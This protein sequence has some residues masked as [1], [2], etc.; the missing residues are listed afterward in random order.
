MIL[1]GKLVG[2]L[3]LLALIA[4][5]FVFLTPSHPTPPPPSAYRLAPG[6]APEP[7]DFGTI[8]Q[9]QARITGLR[10]YSSLKYGDMKGEHQYAAQFDKNRTGFIYWQLT[11]DFPAP[12]KPVDVPL[13]FLWSHPDGTIFYENTI[14][15]KLEADW[16][17]DTYYVWDGWNKPGYWAPGLYRLEIY[18][19]GKLV[20]TSSYEIIP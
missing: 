2:L 9:A 12:G 18:S 19:G 10:F 1:A 16:T 20:A 4:L 11:L 15:I 13:H 3:T 8:P 14:T 17:N 6:L 7:P 5:G